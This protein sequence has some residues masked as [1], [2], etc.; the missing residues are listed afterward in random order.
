MSAKACFQQ[1]SGEIGENHSLLCATKSISG[2]V[3]EGDLIGGKSYSDRSHRGP[4][5]K[6]HGGCLTGHL[7]QSRNEDGGKRIT[8]ACGSIWKMQ[9]VDFIRIVFE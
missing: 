5:K 8:C 7:R 9:G 1:P 3:G 2:I 4:E 6:I